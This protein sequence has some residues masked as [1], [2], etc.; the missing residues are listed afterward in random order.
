VRHALPDF[1]PRHGL[2]SAALVDLFA[3]S[4]AEF[5]Q[6]TEGSAIR[7]TGWRGWRRNLAVALG[8]APSTPAV[9]AALRGAEHDADALVAEHVQWALA[10][11]RRRLPLSVSD[12]L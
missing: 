5:L 4:E 1:E 8:N 2:D 9:L 6:R 7:R 3:W 12:V 11:H 10:Q